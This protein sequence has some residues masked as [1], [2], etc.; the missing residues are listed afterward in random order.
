MKQI[1]LKP[2]PTLYVLVS[3]LLIILL[4]IGFVFLYIR[5]QHVNNELNTTRPYGFP[6]HQCEPGAKTDTEVC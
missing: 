2:I 6:I 5:L 1:N 3:S 4:I